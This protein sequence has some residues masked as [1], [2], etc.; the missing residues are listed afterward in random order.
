MR[1]SLMPAQSRYSFDPSGKSAAFAGMSLGTTSPVRAGC[2]L[3]PREEHGGGITGDGTAFEAPGAF[4]D[5]TALFAF[6]ASEEA[7]YITA[8]TQNL[9]GGSY[10]A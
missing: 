8:T 1:L 3:A 4:D 6:L 5:V 2:R 9:N 10:I 7:G